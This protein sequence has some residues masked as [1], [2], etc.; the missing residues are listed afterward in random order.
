MS[1]RVSACTAAP[2]G[3]APVRART[4][5]RGWCST[6]STAIGTSS[7]DCS[8]DNAFRRW[9]ESGVIVKADTLEELAAEAGLPADQL[10]ATV[11]RFNGF[12]RSGLDADFHRGESAYDR[13]CG[14]PTNKPNPA[15]APACQRHGA[16]GHAVHR[17]WG[18]GRGRGHRKRDL[19]D[20]SRRQGVVEH[21]AI[22]LRPRGRWVRRRARTVDID[23]AAGSGAISRCHCRSCRSK[24]CCTGCAETATNCTR[25]RNS[26]RQRAFRG[27]SC[28]ACAPTASLARRSST[29]SWTATR[30]GFTYG[31]RFAG[32]VFPGE[33]L[34]ANI[35]KEGDRLLATI[36][37]PTRDNAVVLSGVEL[38]PA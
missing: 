16:I 15:R 29:P 20:R 35:W 11:E 27:R 7:R 4:S 17:G 33:T 31:A 25:I 18:Q 3:R 28:T 8:P 6:S 24:P 38:V 36:T 13:Y 23:C 1:R 26:L 37:A 22:D 2:T 10:T 14:D 9:L 12:A 19:G 32:V 21:A 5:P 30:A 34:R